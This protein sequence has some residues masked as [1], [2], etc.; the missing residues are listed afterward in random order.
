MSPTPLISILTENKLNRDNFQEWKRNLLI[1][2]S[3]EKHKFVLDETCPPE[4]H[5]EARN[6]W[7][8][9]DS[10]TQCYMLVNMSSVLQKQ[11]ENFRTAKE[12]IKI[13]EDLLGCQFILA[14]QSIITNL[15]NSQQKRHSGQRS[16]A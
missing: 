8:D 4:A 1:V 6:H 13:L 7:R 12:I 10:I 14:Q 2:L 5:P 11:N 15:M 16:Y 3:C 9:F